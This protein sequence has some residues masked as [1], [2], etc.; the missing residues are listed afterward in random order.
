MLQEDERR[1][2]DLTTFGFFKGGILDVKLVNFMM[3]HGPVY[4]E[5]I[6]VVVHLCRPSE[7]GVQVSQG[8]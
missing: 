7:L 3:P 5:V 2:V 8:L 6:A 1:F 4:G